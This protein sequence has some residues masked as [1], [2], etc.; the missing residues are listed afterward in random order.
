MAK[1]PKIIERIRTRLTRTGREVKF[2][3]VKLG[4]DLSKFVP[5]SKSLLEKLGARKAYVE[6]GKRASVLS[7]IITPS[8]FRKAKLEAEEGRALAPVEVKRIHGGKRYVTKYL[9]EKLRH[10]PNLGD[11]SLYHPSFWNKE[12]D[13]QENWMRDQRR[14]L[15]LA[16]ERSGIRFELTE[17]GEWIE[18]P[19][20][21]ATRKLMSA[22]D[23]DFYTRHLFANEELYGPIETKLLELP[24]GEISPRA[25]RRGREPGRATQTGRSVGSYRGTPHGTRRSAA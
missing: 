8:M 7:I 4:A 18:T 25:I 11:H 5:A 6:A 24:P 9:K 19:I 17:N 12:L 2:A 15:K 23:W 3:S 1:V 13:F 20:A 22:A 21:D 10:N 14:F 16:A